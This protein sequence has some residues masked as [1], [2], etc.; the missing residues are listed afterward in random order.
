MKLLW[1]YSALLL[2]LASLAAAASDPQVSGTIQA[3][4]SEM[5]PAD[6]MARMKE[7]WATERWFTFPKI[8]ENAKY[9]KGVLSGIGLRDVELVSPP[10]DGATQYG[11]WTMPFAWDV[12]QATLEIVEPAVPA[13]MRLLADFQKIPTSIPMWGSPTP[14]GPVTAEVVELRNFSAQEMERTEMKGKMVLVRQNPESQK[15]P[16][17]KKGV[18]GVISG[19]TENASLRD[20]HQW[21]N[22]WGD[23]GWGYTKYSNPLACFSISPRQADFLS[24]LLKK[25]KVVVRANADARYYKG[26]YPYDTGV[27]QGTTNE[28]VLTLGHT[29]EQGANDNAN[30]VS[31]MIEAMATIKRLVD[32][33][34]LK[35]PRRSIRILA[36]PEIYGSMHYVTANPERMRRTVAAICLDTPAGEY[37]SPASQLS[38]MMTPDVARSYV[39]ALI[40]TIAESYLSSLTPPRG[41]RTTQFQVST[42]TYFS[43]PMIGV[44]TI[45]A[46]SANAVSVHHNS[47]DTPDRVDVRS[48][49]DLTVVT[50]AF[51]YAVASAG[52]AE[53][54]WLADIT[55]NRAAANMTRVARRSIEGAGTAAAGDLARR[56]G[57][58]LE[59]IAYNEERDEAAVVST[60][61]LAA[62]AAREELRASLAPA[63]DKVRQ[64]AAQER[65]KLNEA[66]ERRAAALGMATPVKPAVEAEDARMAEAARI[67]VKRKRFGTITLDDLPRDQWEGQHSAAWD[68]TLQ[69]AQFWCDGNRNLA[70]VIRR[71]TLERGTLRTDLVS[72]F[73]FLA[74]KGYVELVETGK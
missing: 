10:A 8:E 71:T 40:E 38:F 69:T 66:V 51:L 58:G 70:E 53:V 3:I 36:M 64:A 22:S 37:D 57:D 4:R 2:P 27:I 68:A 54:P 32:G 12:K 26:V 13:E 47:E 73:R 48:V 55:A 41:Y 65:A 60:L 35:Q 67:I 14:G 15:T 49:G 20:G 46:Q 34:K 19:A 72:W 61:R 43:D 5:R 23:S 63:L 11:F 56:L 59:Q 6:A 28:E 30:G 7:M 24:D 39:N 21:I 16:L 44:P 42:D 52:E 62:P 74:K 45:T 25:G 50:A 29:A 18:A 17:L 33:G 1:R 31:V 9:L